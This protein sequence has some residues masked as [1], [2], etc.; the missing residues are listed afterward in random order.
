MR[1]VFLA[2]LSWAEEVT[3]YLIVWLAFVGG[4]VTLRT[5]GHI[6]ID[7]S[8]LTLSPAGARRLRVFVC[9]AMLVFF[10]AFFYY[11]GLHTLRVMD[12]GRITPVP[13][14]P[15]WLIYLAMP[16][17]SFLMGVRTTQILC[18]ALAGKTGKH[19]MTAGLVFGLLALCRVN[20]EDAG[21]KAEEA[22]NPRGCG[23][24]GGVAVARSHRRALSASPTRH[25]P[26]WSARS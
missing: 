22:G 3:I 25:R 11:S 6:S 20:P 16:V 10:A 13:E 21:K 8:P 9:L 24:F 18:R 5:F 7:L 2:A 19:G 1:Y 14:A 26:G 15:M 23:D 4:S 17:G 12:T